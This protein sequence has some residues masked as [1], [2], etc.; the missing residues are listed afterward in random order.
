MDP[1]TQRMLLACA[2]SAGGSDP[3]Y[4][5]DVYSTRRYVGTGSS[6]S[7][8]N[9]I[10]ISGEG[11][12]VWC[13]NLNDSVSH[14][15]QDT[16]RGTNALESNSSSAEFSYTSGISSFTS[17]GFTVG[18][19]NAVNGSGKHICSWTFR[20]CPGFFDI[21]TYTGN[22][23]NRA[24]AH[25]LGSKPGFMMIKNLST[26]NT[27][28]RTYHRSRGATTVSYTHLTLPTICSV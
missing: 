12:L 6:Q 10:D 25:N 21:V 4:V 22:G 15:L 7:I 8:N 5:D 17:S 9:G 28:W 20:K 16:E 27:Y 26:N 23:S 14:I 24:I 2:G 13:K 1:K 19:A 11:G 3:I 18:N